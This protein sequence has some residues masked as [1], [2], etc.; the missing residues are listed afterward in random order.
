MRKLL[1]TRPDHDD[2]T[3]IISKWSQP[4]ID[5][6]KKRGVKVLDLR[7]GKASREK[8][9][10]YLGNHNPKF[11]ILNGH[12]EHNLIYGHKNEVLLK[13][14]DG[15]R[16]REKIIYSI[17]C[18]AART[19]GARVVQ[20]GAECFIGYYNK[21]VFFYDAN[22]ISRP[23]EDEKLKSFFRPTNMIPI[24][25]VKKNLV[26]DAVEKAR[27]EFG[28]EILKWRCSSDLAAPFM[29]QALLWDKISLR[30]IGN[31]NSRFE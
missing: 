4:I 15:R 26:K 14:E 1:I 28:K 20:N 31:P 10:Q 23:L 18:D 6:A 24:G 9:F 3:F 13:S 21:F 25:I 12:G 11:L 30:L 7:G 5:E 2:A 27:K 16:L 29:I 8:F 17:A 19:L 22:K